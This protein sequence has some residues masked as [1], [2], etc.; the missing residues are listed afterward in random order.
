MARR[1]LKGNPNNPWAAAAQR[2]REERGRQ[3]IC[4]HVAEDGTAPVIHSGYRNTI[5][6][7]D[8]AGGCLA[9]V[10][11]AQRLCSHI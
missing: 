4:I 6:L 1:P 7:A 5:Y 9:L 11:A 10:P 8:P 3:F 2:R